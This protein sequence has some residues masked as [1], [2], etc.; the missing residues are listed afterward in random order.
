M[1]SEARAGWW[2][3]SGDC[4]NP[5]LRLGQWLRLQELLTTQRVPKEPDNSL[6][7]RPI[8]YLIKS[9]WLSSYPIY[10]RKRLNQ[11]K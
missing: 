8:G 10:R 5:E 4:N 6:L 11:H 9:T 2:A 7:H 3:W 1:V